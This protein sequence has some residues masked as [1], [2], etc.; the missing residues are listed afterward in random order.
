LS[1]DVTS[2]AFPPPGVL[3]EASG[4]LPTRI[5]HKRYNNKAPAMEK[6][7]T[8]WR[9]STKAVCSSISYIWNIKVLGVRFIA[10]IQYEG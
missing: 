4:P 2:T 5:L 8:S 10:R 6:R 1:A 9:A 7:A 3:P